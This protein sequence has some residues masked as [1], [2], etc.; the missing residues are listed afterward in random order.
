[1]FTLIQRYGLFEEIEVNIEELMHLNITESIN[2]FLK[3]KERLTP[4][5]VVKRLEGNRYY[6]YLVRS[7]Y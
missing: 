7:A 4:T 2:L 6:Q 5:L 3:H 1:M